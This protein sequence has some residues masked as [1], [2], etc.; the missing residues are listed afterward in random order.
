MKKLIIVIL[1]LAMIVP[2]TSMADEISTEEPRAPLVG[3]WYLL[4]EKEELPEKMQKELNKGFYT[5]P[6]V[7]ELT[8]YRITE[9]GMI[10]QIAGNFLGSYSEAHGGNVGGSWIK[11]DES[12]YIVTI[13]GKGSGIVNFEGTRMYIYFGDDTYFAFHKMETFVL[14]TDLK[15]S[16]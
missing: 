16:K 3:Y 15:K 5:S 8:I 4:I 6:M 1:I 7:S 11:T 9:D 12:E 14:E 13:V 2:V 10:Y